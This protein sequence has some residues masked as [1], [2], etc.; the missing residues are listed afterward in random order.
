MWFIR[1]CGR[2]YYLV[3]VCVCV[4]VRARVRARV[5]ACVSVCVCLCGTGRNQTELWNV[6]LATHSITQYA[7][8]SLLSLDFEFA[9]INNNNDKI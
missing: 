3:L 6:W 1:Q 5:C 9:I 2:I 8:V 7:R 4:C